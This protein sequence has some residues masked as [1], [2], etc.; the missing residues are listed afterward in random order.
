MRF[1]FGEILSR[2]AKIVWKFKIL[3]LFG[4]LYSCGRTGGSSNGSSSQ[5]SGST[6]SSLGENFRMPNPDGGQ[7]VLIIGVVILVILVLAALIMA[8]SVMGKIGLVRGT[9]KAED[10]A[11][12]MSFGEL[13]QTHY[14]GRMFWLNILVG[15]VGLAA[16]LLIAVPL[17]L[18]AIPMIA[19]GSPGAANA[20]P[21]IAIA[22]VCVLPF[23]CILLPV[24]WVLGVWFELAQNALII[25]DLGVIASIKRGWAVFR[26]NLVNSL[27]MGFILWLVSLGAGILVTLPVIIF[28]LPGVL[29]VI[30][31]GITETKGLLFGGLGLALLCL[32]AYLPIGLLGSGIINAYQGSAWALTYLRLTGAAPAAAVAA[33]PIPAVEDLP[34]AI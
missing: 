3:W 7:I 9:Q 11:E 30:A 5:S 12:T 28:V 6:G 29:A 19:S 2:A 15:L 10:G 32:C 23:L 22:L 34:P 18:A 8:I 20:M 27:G 4:I 26:Q 25:E 16:L 1:D 17:I 14:F 24:S 21:I 31:G 13:W 33:A